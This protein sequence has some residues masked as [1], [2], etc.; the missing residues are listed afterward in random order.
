MN[1]NSNILPAYPY[2]HN[3]PVERYNRVNSMIHKHRSPIF[4]RT[5][6]IRLG[7][8]SSATPRTA[9]LRKRQFDLRSKIV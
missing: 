4:P 9:T 5:Q 6:A 3:L 1:M 8:S 2:V 7:I